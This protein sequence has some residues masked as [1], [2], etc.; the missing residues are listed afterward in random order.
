MILE[1]IGPTTR[2]RAI[3]SNIFNSPARQ[4]LAG[5]LRA[6]HRARM[7][8]S[9][10]LKLRNN[11]DATPLSHV[12]P[13]LTPVTCPA[14]AKS[15]ATPSEAHARAAAAEVADDAEDDGISDSSHARAIFAA[16]NSSENCAPAGV[17]P[18]S[19]RF[20]AC[21]N[22]AAAVKNSTHSYTHAHSH[23]LS[24]PCAD[25]PVIDIDSDDEPILC[26]SAAPIPI[27]TC[28]GCLSPA[29]I[30]SGL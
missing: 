18:A 3:G 14:V 26:M 17:N 24:G 25:A 9:S 16:E 4:L 6:R 28:I 11:A 10:R 2:E 8:F 27:I 5:Q 12:K 7:G 13:A 23:A 21:N 19:K 1:S 15:A 29:L 20:K 30:L 22:G